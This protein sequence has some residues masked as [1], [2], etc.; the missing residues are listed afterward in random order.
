[1][2]CHSYNEMDCTFCF[3]NSTGRWYDIKICPDETAV[4]SFDQFYESKVKWFNFLN[5]LWASR[6]IYL[7]IRVEIC[8]CYLLRTF[9]L[10]LICWWISDPINQNQYS[11]NT[12]WSYNDV[13]RWIQSGK[14]WLVYLLV[15]WSIFRRWSYRFDIL[16]Y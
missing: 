4:G 1:M 3:D 12:L 7:E 5:E 13:F 14:I 8:L 10:T 6:C 11:S 16:K 9:E 15:W 2:Q